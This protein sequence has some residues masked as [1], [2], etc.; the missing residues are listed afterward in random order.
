MK[1][2]ANLLVLLS[3]IMIIFTVFSSCKKGNPE[4]EK[5]AKILNINEKILRPVNKAATLKLKVISESMSIG[6]AARIEKIIKAGADAN[7]VN[8]L[9]TQPLQ[10]ADYTNSIGM[11][12]KKIPAGSF[13]MGSCKLSID[14]PSGASSDN[15][16]YD[17]E[18]PQHKVRISKSFQMGIFEVTLGHFEKFIAGAGRD[19]LLTDDLIKYNSHGNSA[20]VSFVSWHDA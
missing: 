5:Y 8:L 18:T 2:S 7:T 19:V 4:D 14:C 17:D 16:A 1:K 3:M 11:K 13:Y 12:F 20:A 9:I 15:E 6:D 10:G